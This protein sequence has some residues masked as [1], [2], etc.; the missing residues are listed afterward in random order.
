MAEPAHDGDQRILSAAEQLFSTHG[1][2]ATSM[3][4]IATTA[5]VSKAS[6]FHHFGSKQELY[7]AVLQNACR[8]LHDA[9]V[10]HDDG[11]SGQTSQLRHFAATHLE[12]LFER[13]NLSRVVL[14]SLLDSGQELGRDMAEQVFSEQFTR[15]VELVR[16]G[17]DAGL[18][19]PHID[20]AHAAIAVVGMNTMLFQ[21][22]NVLRHL[23]GGKFSDFHASGGLLFD[24]VLRGL[25]S[26][27][28]VKA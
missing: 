12:H 18:I 20:G 16:S 8:E 17:Q 22:W 27:Q 13:E 9:W 19:S 24:I 26:Q 2:D 10:A 5:G 1:F 25:T 11:S 3:Q 28:G 6:V 23:P 4:R 15:L 21:S 7:L 14:R